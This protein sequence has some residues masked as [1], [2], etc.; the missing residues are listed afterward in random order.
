MKKVILSIDTGIDDAMA[1]A[2]VL[3][4]K[5]LELIGI[6]GTYGN[7]YTKQG[8]KNDLALL[9]MLGRTDIPVYLGNEHAIDKDDFE[10]SEVS[11]DIHGQNGIGEVE[12]PAAS[13]QVETGD[14]VDFIIDSVKKYGKDLTVIATGPMTDLA[15][16]LKKYPAF[17]DEV[18]QVVIMGGALAC[19]GNVTPYAEANIHQ[20]PLA[21][22]ILFES[23]T[24][25]IMVGLDVT[26]RT[27]ISLEDTQKWRDT[28]TVAGE[29]YADIVDYYIHIYD[30]YSPYL[31]GGSLH[32]P[33]ATCAAV[34]PEW[35]TMLP[36]HMT[37]E[38]E[39]ETAG[40][41]I[42]V[43][44]KLREPNPNVKVCINIE[45]EKVRQDICNTIHSLFTK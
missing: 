23:G 29:K 9:E 7:V 45:A 32:D 39:G 1:L 15:R 36:L 12:V 42:G 8:V 38:T 33:S 18:G 28:K 44:E 5:E 37:V 14:G 30:K 11:A 26:M 19:T 40:R 20:D 6:V 25:V 43:M 31:H 2:Y 10:V 4:S 35:F 21:A 22:K 24:P 41:T 17:K 13:R 34:H 27:P 3:G 16:T